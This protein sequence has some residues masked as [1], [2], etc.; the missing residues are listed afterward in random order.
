MRFSIIIP[1]Y[2][3]EK[4]LEKCLDSV[5]KQSYKDYEIILIDDGST[6]KSG[7]I[8]DG[9]KTNY[10]NKDITVIHQKNR[11]LAGARNK[12]LDTAKGE[13]IIFVDSD[14]YI[15]TDAIER[16][17]NYIDK[18]S[19]D[20]YSF[21]S[22]L[23]DEDDKI[24]SKQIFVPEKTIN[25]FKSSKDKLDFLENKFMQYKCGWEAWSR[26]YNKAIIDKN[27]LRFM[28]TKD[29]LAEDYLFSIQYLFY[30][31]KYV[32]ICDLLYFYR[33]REGSLIHNVNYEQVL[34]K[35]L[36]W[37]NIAY[38]TFK[39]DNILRRNFYRIFFCLINYHIQYM[40]S[41]LSDNKLAPIFK[42]LKIPARWRKEIKNNK[43]YIS[44]YMLHRD[45]LSLL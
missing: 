11:G 32:Q 20:L 18:N 21:N 22:V 17:S 42:S 14:D 39:K 3:V 12:G 35:L 43:E 16:I 25:E 5:V 15:S 24:I 10:R 29:V 38:K 9:Y 19:S 45:W 8:A 7:E 36:N 34:P 26:V 44:K 4:Y 41:P 13:W 30:V 28:N 6:D 40:L 23:I 31:D 33:Q 37:S 27:N 2:N 1:I